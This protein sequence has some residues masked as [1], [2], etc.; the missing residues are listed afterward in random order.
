MSSSL[1]RTEDEVRLT[2]RHRIAIHTLHHIAGWSEREIA[3]RI[4]ESQSTVNYVIT[5]PLTPRS[6]RV[7]A[8]KIDTLKRQEIVQLL[9]ASPG[10]RR[11]THGQLKA[12]LGLDCSDNTLR[13]A[14]RN[15]GFRRCVALVKPYLSDDYKEVRLAF[16]HTFA[17]WTV[18][19]WLRVNFVDEAQFYIGDR[20][21][22]YVTRRPHER[23]S[24]DCLQ[25]KVHKG[26]AY[27]V[28]GQ[29]CNGTIGLLTRW[30][31]TVKGTLTGE[32]YA[33]NIL[34]VSLSQSL[35]CSTNKLL[36]D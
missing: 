18:Q 28:H 30:D 8:Y 29:I 5:Y 20:Q 19:D 33:N 26:K 16:A 4:G 6:N 34:P 2:H 32:G 24:Q 15:E 12:R 27:M 9:E 3:R 10:A 23:E 14:L 36:G 21:R 22:Q 11:L 25:A 1:V 7:A 35:A 13:I 17:D 31:R